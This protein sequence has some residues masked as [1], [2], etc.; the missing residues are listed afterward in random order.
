MTVIMALLFPGITNIRNPSLRCGLLFGLTLLYFIFL[1]ITKNE[2]I[3]AIRMIKLFILSF[4]YIVISLLGMICA[5]G[6]DSI[7]L[8]SVDGVIVTIV[9][10]AMLF[11]FV[12]FLV[13]V[14]KSEA[15][16]EY[17]VAKKNE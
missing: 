1:L 7:N 10:V 13:N 6:Y 12:C 9:C 2:T 3:R 8:R 16:R 11:N 4:T 17:Q 5:V 14:L 15:Y